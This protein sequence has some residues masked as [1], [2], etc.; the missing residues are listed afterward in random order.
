MFFGWWYFQEYTK[1]EKN[2][3]PFFMFRK[4]EQHRIETTYHWLS[5][6]RFGTIRP[7]YRIYPLQGG[8]YLQYRGRSRRVPRAPSEGDGCRQGKAGGYGRDP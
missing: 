5:R 1:H 7:T 6:Q 3:T 4:K 8:P 2:A